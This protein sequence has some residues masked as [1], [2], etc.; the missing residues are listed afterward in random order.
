MR[1]PTSKPSSAPTAEA[2]PLISFER[3]VEGTTVSVPFLVAGSANTFEA[4]LTVEASV[5]G[6]GILCALDLLATSGSGTPG[7]WQGTIAFPPPESAGSVTLRAYA[8]SAKDGSPTDLVA[9][10]ITVSAERPA[11]FLTTPVCGDIVD[12]GQLLAVTGRAEVFEAALTIE[13]RDASGT[14]L[15]AQQ[16]VADECCVESNFAVLLSVPAGLA[17]GSYDV[18]AFTTS[19]VDGSIQNEFPVQIQVRS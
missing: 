4:A 11:I 10:T 16:V 18:V 7:T 9:Q 2:D 12:A 1:P 8:H 15:L 19:A 3:P 13:L 5:A 14:A 6:G 17:A